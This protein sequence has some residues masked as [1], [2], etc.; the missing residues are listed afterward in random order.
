[1]NDTHVTSLRSSQPERF[2]WHTTSHTP[3]GAFESFT[4]IIGREVESD[5]RSKAGVGGDVRVPGTATIAA[6]EEVHGGRSLEM[7]KPTP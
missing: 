3:Y 1:M 6:A 2:R 4:V 5:G 7:T